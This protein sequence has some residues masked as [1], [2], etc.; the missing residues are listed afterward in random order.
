MYIVASDFAA[1]AAAAAAA[2]SLVAA[3]HP[4]SMQMHC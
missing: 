2:A 3:F 4:Y 1:A